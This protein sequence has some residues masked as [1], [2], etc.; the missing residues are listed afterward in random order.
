MKPVQILTNKKN[1]GVDIYKS[2]SYVLE[3][4]KENLHKSV[5]ENLFY[6]QIKDW[7]NNRNKIIKTIENKFSQKIIVRSSAMG[8]DSINNSGAGAYQSIQNVDPKSKKHVIESINSV[9]D[10]Y[11]KKQNFDPKNEVLVQTQSTNII[12]SGV[13]FTRTPEIGSP[14]YV[15]NFE[16]GSATDGVTKGSINN[17]LKIFRGTDF[18]K[19][20]KK[21]KLLLKSIKEIETL[22]KSQILDIEF[23]I[24]DSY[25]II[26]FQVRPI[27]SLKNTLL[28]SD[29]K[30]K[31]LISKNKNLFRKES[32]KNLIP[33]KYSV[34]SDMADWN[35]A[36]IIGNNP[37]NLDY[38]LY[39]FLIMDSAWHLG[40]SDIG[41]QKLSKKN[42]M[43]KF[44]NK[45]Y[46]NIKS[47]FYSLLPKNI[48]NK[49][50]EKL[51]NFY[52][53]KLIQNT[54]LHD[55]VEFD[56]LFTC[57]E[58]LLDSRVQ[59]LKDSNFSQG[60]INNIK[61]NIIEFTN[62]VLL[63][64]EKILRNNSKAIKEMQK[65]RYII[66]NELKNG[67][68]NYK[69]LISAS[70]KLLK[71][72]IIL[73]TIPFSTMARIAFIASINLRSLV[74]IGIIDQVSADAFLNSI[75]TPLSEFR[76]DLLLYYNKEISKRIF[77][78]KYG[79]LRPG[80]Y[81]I[82]ASRYDND[83]FFLDNLKFDGSIN[84]KKQFK[85]PKSIQ[86]TLEKINLVFP[87]MDFFD[88]A[89]SA[90]VERENLKFEFT[91]NLSDALELISEASEQ[92]NFSKNEISNLKIQ[93]IF[94]DVKNLQKQILVKKWRKSI[95]K[96][97]YKHMLN[98]H[99]A[100]PPI[101]SSENDFD[102]ISYPSAKP[103]FITSKN[104]VSEIV[105]LN[106]D[107]KIN[108]LENKIILLENADPGFDW[109]FSYNISGLI[110]K[111]GGVASHM[112]IRC[113]ELGIP[114]AIGCGEILYEKLQLASKILLDCVNN[115]IIII[116]HSKSDLFVEEKRLLKSLGY[117]K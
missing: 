46:V 75:H 36:E 114:A 6:F 117:I 115:Q 55:K 40:R 26:I 48:S 113:S 60:D 56:I 51:M 102:L 24:N 103:N 112:A 73:G 89:K 94:N 61:K 18:K 54:Y 32:N 19:I 45:P 28:V 84:V 29:T 74:K 92:L 70:E 1:L 105:F 83:S 50:K 16:D 65:N 67:K 99:L 35:P 3:F 87:K 96:E 17:T 53:K 9:I 4:L 100:L 57:N 34:F 110:T 12:T 37:N 59:E 42:L 10:S 22:L 76:N 58:I 68:K 64:F 52:L 5:I 95:N 11:K 33:G 38:S 15:I 111:Y 41:Y 8:E 108:D 2:K 43:T 86:K 31:K 72:C 71:D 88:F 49:N 44:G 25:Q 62:N 27:S 109:L 104:I 7:E 13:V 69:N 85:K 93:T 116:E 82:L 106:D 39:H 47:S 98:D 97:K 63:D 20:P 21:W 23:G 14:Y 79:H 30:I 101:I 107:T 81:D 80:T 77:L 78:N 66:H 90:I 91:K